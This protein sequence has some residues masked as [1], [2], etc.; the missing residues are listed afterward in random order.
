[1]AA[2]AID[3]TQKPLTFSTGISGLRMPQTKKKLTPD[4]DFVQRLK[5]SG[6]GRM[7]R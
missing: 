6:S 1:V 2:D 5:P 4:T 7:L 3:E